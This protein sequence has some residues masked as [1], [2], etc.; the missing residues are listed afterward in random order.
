MT[1][2]SALW[3]PILL[4]AVGVFVLSSL[5]HMGSPW[6]KNDYPGVP[7]ESKVADALRSFRIPPGDYMMPRPGSRAEMRSP[8]FAERVKA[9]PNLMLTVIPDGPRSMGKYLVSWF[10]FVL[11]AGTF[12]A[13]IAACA[14]PPGAARSCVVKFVGVTAFIGY[15]LALWPMSIW[16]HRRWSTTFKATFDG[17]VYAALTALVFGWL[18]PR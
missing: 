6:H 3:L 2:L 17:L 7:D 12:A 14:L 13:Y 16:Y 9:G 11:V 15:S 5:I 4:S 18:W 8:E 10:I 1:A